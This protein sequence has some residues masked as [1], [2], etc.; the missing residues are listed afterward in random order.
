MVVVSGRVPGIC[1]A[2]GAAGSADMFSV[3]GDGLVTISAGGLSVTSGGA[4][5]GGVL[6]ASSGLTITAG[7]LSIVS[8]GATVGGILTASNGLTVA[9][10]GLSVTAGGA[11][12]SSA[13]T[14]T[15][16]TSGTGFPALTVKAT[17]ALG[18]S[19]SVLAISSEMA[20]AATFFLIKVS[21]LDY[22][23]HYL[24]SV[25]CLLYCA[26]SCSIVGSL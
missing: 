22:Y 12:I 15:V 14:S 26:I 11:A 16:L 2:Q 24:S 7:G 21:G 5:I 25:I 6:T 10:G 19:N 9:A 17:S 3:R 8:G 4:T 1:C 13:G 23:V 18:Y 20:G